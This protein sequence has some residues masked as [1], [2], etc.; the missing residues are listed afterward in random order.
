MANLKLG[1]KGKRVAGVQARLREL[2]FDEDGVFGPATEA[3]VTAFQEAQGLL[4]DGVVGPITRA[5][6]KRAD[7]VEPL[8]DRP[9][10]LELDRTLALTEDQYFAEPIVKDLIV[11]HHTVGA[12]ARST[13]AHFQNTDSKVATAYVVERDGTIFEIF[14]PRHWAFHLGIKGT[15]GRVDRRSVGIEIASEGQLKK[16]G[17]RFM[18]FGGKKRFDGKVYDH[19]E[20]WRREQYFAAYTPEQTDAVCR[21]VDHLCALFGI[22]RRTP[23]DRLSFDEALV[24]YTG[25]IGHHHVRKDKTDLHPG[26]DWDALVEKAA[27]ALD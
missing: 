21:L 27:L 14:D 10:A 12:T 25:V 1:S 23:A 6:L 16:K 3:A 15:G 9:P 19:G 11:L 20:K 24:D 5:A 2:G 26:F 17:G 4:P 22:E 18:A 13:I 8:P 7:V